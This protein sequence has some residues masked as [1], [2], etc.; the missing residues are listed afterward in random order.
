MHEVCVKNSHILK[1]FALS[2]IILVSF[3][4]LADRSAQHTNNAVEFDA[5]PIVTKTSKTQNVVKNRE[6]TNAP[7]FHSES[8]L[9]KHAVKNTKKVLKE[10]SGNPYAVYSMYKMTN[11]NVPVSVL[12]KIYYSDYRKT[13]ESIHT[14]FDVQQSDKIERIVEVVYKVNQKEHVALVDWNP[15]KQTRRLGSKHVKIS[16]KI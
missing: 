16:D 13:P 3:T 11:E 5:Q 10:R 4:L 12:T 2:Q 6:Q 15:K 8:D 14:H 1:F 9:I 7:F